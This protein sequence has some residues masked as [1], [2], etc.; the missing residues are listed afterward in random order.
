MVV[1]YPVHIGKGTFESIDFV[2]R[3]CLSGFFLNPSGNDALDFIAQYIVI[4]IV[5]SVLVDDHKN[6]GILQFVVFFRGT[7]CFFHRV[8]GGILLYFFEYNIFYVQL[9]FIG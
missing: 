8:F 9:I 4:E 3:Y 2:M 1:K 6:V 7:L 5:F